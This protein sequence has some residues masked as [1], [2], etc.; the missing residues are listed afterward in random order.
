MSA[1]WSEDAFKVTS[2][3][4]PGLEYDYFGFEKHLHRLS[5]NPPGDP[6]FA[7]KV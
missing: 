5:Y 2:H 4:R 7:K 6:K 1:H 3:D